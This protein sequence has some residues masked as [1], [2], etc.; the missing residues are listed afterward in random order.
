MT[1][2]LRSPRTARSARAGGFGLELQVLQL[3]GEDE[4]AVI[5]AEGAADAVGVELKGDRVDWR[6]LAFAGREI[7]QGHGPARQP[8]QAILASGGLDIAGAR[9]DAAADHRERIVDLAAVVGAVEDLGVQGRV[10]GAR[11]SD[12]ALHMGRRKERR[13]AEGQ[14]LALRLLEADAEA[15]GPALGLAVDG[16]SLRPLQLRVGLEPERLAV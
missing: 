3:A 10:A 14:G 2:P 1:R 6:A 5:E 16:A 12:E 4:V 15:V 9:R 13:V 8:R 7:A 11:R